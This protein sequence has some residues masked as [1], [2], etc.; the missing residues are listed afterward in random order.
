MESNG[1]RRSMQ[2]TERLTSL[3]GNN[4][5][6]ILPHGCGIPHYHA[7]ACTT[8]SCFF[9]VLEKCSTHTNSER[10]FQTARKGLNGWC[11]SRT[12]QRPQAT[13]C[14][15]APL[16]MEGEVCRNGVDQRYDFSGFVW[17]Q[18]DLHMILETW[19]GMWHWWQNWTGVLLCYVESYP[20]CAKPKMCVHARFW[21]GFFQKWWKFIRRINIYFK[22]DSSKA[23]R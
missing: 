9:P 15:A 17:F 23:L 22:T 3:E 6:L 2:N 14:A 4:Y 18:L 21:G 12:L 13:R 7:I 16:A 10:G 1:K 8:C 11:N 19:W 5:D 20:W